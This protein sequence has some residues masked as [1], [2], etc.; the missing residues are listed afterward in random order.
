LTLVPAE[1]SDATGINS[2]TGNLELL[3]TSSIVLP[4]NPVAPTTAIFME[5]KLMIQG[6]Y[7]L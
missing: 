1:R 7:F 3:N 2:V 5:N 6:Y 4:T